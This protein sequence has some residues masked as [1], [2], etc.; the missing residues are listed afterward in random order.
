MDNSVKEIQDQKLVFSS[1]ELIELS[2]ERRNGDIRRAYQQ[3]INNVKNR[4]ENKGEIL[5]IKIIF[6][7]YYLKIK[8]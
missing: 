5:E 4:G 1:E 3:L 7:E 6:Y 8:R 2:A